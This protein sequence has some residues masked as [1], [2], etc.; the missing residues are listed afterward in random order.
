[1]KLIAA[2]VV[3][4]VML[5]G[6]PAWSQHPKAEVSI[7]YSYLHFQAIDYESFAGQYE[8]GQAYNL[9]G[10]GAAFV[11]NFGP[12]IGLKAEFQGY[13]NQTRTVVLPPGTALN[14]AGASVGVQGDIF[15]YL[16]GPQFGK[17]SGVFRP[18][19]QALFGGAHSNVYRNAY[20]GLG[21]TQAGSAPSSNA[22]AMDF[23]VGID[24]AVSRRFSIRPIE[25]SY[26]Y[27]K[28][29]N[30]LTANQHSTRYV[31]GV[32]FNLAYTAPPAQLTVACSAT[33]TSVF[34]GEPVNVTATVGSQ[35]PKLGVV[36]SITGD[37]ITAASN[38]ATA[39]A[40]TADLPPGQHTVRC[41]AKE[42]KPGK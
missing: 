40:N 14:P 5:T 6:P 25:A 39:T 16:F 23:G 37:G 20:S 7:D 31:G 33:P 9:N 24:I 13:A 17:R 26:L 42:G 11:Y 27:S 19:G 29:N 4:T 32:V 28:F 41:D 18:Y 22:F 15:T 30:D 2:L 3:V 35:H 36:T 38:S 10:G 34:P 8:F 1:M 21:L 12:M